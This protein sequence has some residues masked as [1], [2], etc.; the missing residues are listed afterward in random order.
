[1][2]RSCTLCYGTLTVRPADPVQE[3]TERAVDDLDTGGG[4]FSAATETR[5]A[6]LALGDRGHVL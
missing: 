1:M 5:V 2:C 6:E 3:D 4:E